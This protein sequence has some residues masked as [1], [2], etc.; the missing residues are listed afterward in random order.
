MVARIAWTT[1]IAVLASTGIARADSFNYTH[2]QP[3]ETAKVLAPGEWQV[4]VFNPLRLG[5]DWLEVEVHPL[6]LLA[7]P[8]VDV[9]IPLTASLPDAWQ[10]TAQVGLGVPTMAWRLAK[11]FGLAGDLVPSC[12][13]AEHD[14]A[15]A[16]S[17]QRPGWLIVPKVGVWASRE[18]GHSA[19]SDG[20]SAL[21]LHAEI[22]SGFAFSGQAA[23]PLDAWAPVDVQ[24]APYVG[25]TRAQLRVAYDQLLMPWLRLRGELG[26]YWISRPVGDAALSTLTASVYVGLDVRITAH[27]RLTLGAMAYD[28]DRHQQKTEK[29]ADGF[30][31]YTY[32]RSREVWPTLDFIWSY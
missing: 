4:G 17:C 9:K 26:G 23:P 16:A 32:V 31:T 5:L 6:L 29:T 7:A 19:A 20:Y 11:P 12:K 10:W 18:F 2:L 30:D 8:Q 24:L 3:R 25:R 14:A 15:S 1:L 21:T 27:A 22:A 13:V 28:I